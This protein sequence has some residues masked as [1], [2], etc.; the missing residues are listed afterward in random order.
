MHKKI[1]KQYKHFLAQN[2]KQFQ[3]RESELKAITDFVFSQQ[4]NLDKFVLKFYL[5]QRYDPLS[6]YKKEEPVPEANDI[7]C[8]E[9]GNDIIFN[10][11]IFP[12][13]N[14]VQNTNATLMK[15][16][17]YD[18]SITGASF[19]KNESS[20]F[21]NQVTQNSK[22]DYG[23]ECHVAQPTCENEE[24]E[25]PYEFENVAEGPKNKINRLS[26]TKR[27]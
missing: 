13:E 25:E 21:G 12:Y 17:E 10:N 27:R 20:L 8:N 19:N 11:Y 5:G 7:Y 6:D 9:G 14:M 3:N 24:Y 26:V 15:E 1:H 16:Y 22:G 2:K 4:I 23:S 18:Y